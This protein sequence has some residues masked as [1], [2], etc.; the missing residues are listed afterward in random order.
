[1]RA[2]RSL[3]VEILNSGPSVLKSDPP[4]PPAGSAGRGLT[5][6]RARVAVYGGDLDAR[7]RLG[8]G[9]RVRA[10]IPLDPL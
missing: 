7:R 2:E 1:M 6:L 3:R 9:Y 8:G 4:G 10:R 5:G